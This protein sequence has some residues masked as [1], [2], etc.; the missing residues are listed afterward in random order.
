L[1]YFL[2]IDKAIEF[3]NIKCVKQSIGKCLKTK[4]D[5]KEKMMTI[6]FKREYMNLIL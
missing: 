5:L 6:Q 1:G 4:E 3:L 2:T